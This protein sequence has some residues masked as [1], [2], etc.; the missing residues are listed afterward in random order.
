MERSF[1]P[2]NQF[3]G[4]V[5]FKDVTFTYPG[6]QE[7]VLQNVSFKVEPGERV[8]ILGHVG[9]GKTTIGRL[10]AGLYEADSGMV[11]VDGV[12]IRQIAPSDLRENLGISTQDV[13][14]MSTSI[15]ENISLGRS[16]FYGGASALG[17]R[18][19]GRQ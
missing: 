16:R 19:G 6:Q 14:L 2:R 7:P 12:D 10:I 8:A 17:G 9:S 15:E 18:F 5:E 1:L 3:K 4:S 11:L 13:W